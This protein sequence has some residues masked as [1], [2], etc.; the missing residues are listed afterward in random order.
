MENL[1]ASAVDE[2]LADALQSAQ[3]KQQAAEIQ[4]RVADARLRKL[5]KAEPADEDAIELAKLVVA[6]AA[7][8]VAQEAQRVAA[9]KARVSE[10]AE[11]MALALD[12]PEEVEEKKE[13]VVWNWWTATQ[14]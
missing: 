3:L 13:L 2:K 9:I 11:Q 4:R 14:E 7:N 8:R 6:Q 1:A 12:I 5:K 10:A